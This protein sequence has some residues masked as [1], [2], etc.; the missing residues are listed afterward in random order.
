MKYSCTGCDQRQIVFNSSV[1]HEGSGKSAIG[2]ALEVAFIAGGCS[3]KQY[4]KVLANAFGVHAVSFA[5]FYKT[6]LMM[7]PQLKQMLDEQCTLAKAR[8]KAKPENELGSFENAITTADSA[9][10]T[11]GYPQ[12]KFHL[13]GTRLSH[14]CTALLPAYQSER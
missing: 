7:Y 4:K 13:P 2:L 12:P 8:K 9:W 3:Y 11:R 14:R 10:M 6:V 5:Q 1:Q